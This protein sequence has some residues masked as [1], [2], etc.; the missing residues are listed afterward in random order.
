MLV[1]AARGE[2]FQSL[3]DSYKLSVLHLLIAQIKLSKVKLKHLSMNELA[4]S[5][6]DVFMHQEVSEKPNQIL[7][8]RSAVKDS[9]E[10][11]LQLR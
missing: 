4:K 1:G 6:L 7:Q 8:Q 9:N 3:F 5:Q 2:L 11:L 10:T